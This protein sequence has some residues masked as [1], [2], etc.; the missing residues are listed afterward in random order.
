MGNANSQL[1]VLILRYLRAIQVEM[2]NRWLGYTGL[3]LSKMVHTGRVYI[4][5]LHLQDKENHDID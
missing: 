4:W 1:A 5:D 3:L 2:A